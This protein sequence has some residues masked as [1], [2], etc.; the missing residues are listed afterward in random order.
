[1]TK[2]EAILLA[3]A[4]NRGLCVLAPLEAD[5]V[6]EALSVAATELRR[7]LTSQAVRR[8]QDHVASID[9]SNCSLTLRTSAEIVTNA[10]DNLRSVIFFKLEVERL[11]KEQRDRLRDAAR[12]APTTP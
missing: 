11:I 7:A 3:V 6:N 2:D 1:M 4:N 8:A 5:M 10:M 12:E 9:V